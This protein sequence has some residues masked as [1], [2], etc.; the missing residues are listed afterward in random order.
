M[1]RLLSKHPVRAHRRRAFPNDALCNS[2]QVAGCAS[3][4]VRARA[5]AYTRHA[6]NKAR[7]RSV[8]R[9]CGVLVKLSC[10]LTRALKAISKQSRS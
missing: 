10:S 3:R 9:L 6:D 4:V 8:D 7:Y 1:A 5:D 2:A